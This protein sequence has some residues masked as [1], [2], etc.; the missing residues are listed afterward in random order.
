MI[1]KNKNP[2]GVFDSGVGGLSVLK[3]LIKELPNEHFIYFGDTQRVPYGEKSIDELLTCT[4]R[5]LDYFKTRDV[6]AVVVACNTCSANTI[7]QV[8]DEYDFEI[9]G[10]IEPAAKYVCSFDINSV[11]LIATSATVK[12]NA[13]KNEI[14]KKGIKVFQQSCPKLVKYVEAGK[15]TGR[16]VENVLKEYLSPLI[17]NKI[18]KLILGC[19]HYPFLVPA[20]KKLGFENEFFINPAV[21]V[22]AKTKE[23]LIENKLLNRNGEGLQEFYVSGNPNDFKKHSKLFFNK[24][25]N[26]EQILNEESYV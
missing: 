16:E 23:F 9:L 13:Y 8:K 20:I 26:V 15:I 5:I 24:I 1:N 6:K 25:K 4:R 3:E 17:E 22:S 12:S 14:E 21:C 19:T 18:E 10:L 7:T 11:G 2:I